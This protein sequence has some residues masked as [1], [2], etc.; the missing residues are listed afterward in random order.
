LVAHSL[1]AAAALE[2]LRRPGAQVPDQIVFCGPLL[3][4]AWYGPVSLVAHIPGVPYGH[5]LGA[6]DR[7]LARI[8]AQKPLSLPL[9]IY[10][11]TGD[12]VIDADRDRV[13]WQRLVPGAREYRLP[14]RD[15][16]FLQEPGAREEFLVTLGN[17]VGW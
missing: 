10:T 9:T 15:H 3:R 13:D 6:L 4:T 8:E 11:G 14:G 5:W 17:E 16:W 2:A 1:G 12:S 7:W